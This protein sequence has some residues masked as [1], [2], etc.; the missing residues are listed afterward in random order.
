MRLTLILP[1]LLAALPVAAQ[2]VVTWKDDVRGWYLGVDPTIG[3][4]C[5]MTA[6]YD[7]NAFLR[8]QFNPGLGNFQFIVGDQDWSSIEAGKLYDIEVAFGSASPWT[9]EA[10]GMVL[11]NLPGLLLDVPFDKD[12]AATF[13]SEFQQMSRVA[14]TY[15]GT[16]IARLNL[17]GTYAAMEE[18]IACQSAIS[19]ASGAAASQ[20]ADPFAAPQG[21][22]PFR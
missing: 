10:S 19:E 22:D 4:G 5:F 14:V 13:I 20:A 2:D 9:G 8:V 16:E 21:D 3:S 1:G 6:S 7:G 11:G 15:Q 18:V 12:Q 17:S